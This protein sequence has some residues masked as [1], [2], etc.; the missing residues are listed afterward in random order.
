MP[1][2]TA[3]AHPKPEGVPIRN[4]FQKCGGTDDPEPTLGHAETLAQYGKRI[5]RDPCMLPESH[6]ARQRP[7]GSDLGFLDQ[8]LAHCKLRAL[9]ETA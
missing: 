3:G 7:L 9:C 8:N 5:N 6:I 2:T 1:T 4:R